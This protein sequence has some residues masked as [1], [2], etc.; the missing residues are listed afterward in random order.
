MPLVAERWRAVCDR[1]PGVDEARLVPE[2]IRDLIGLMVN[3][4]LVE[5]RRRVAEAG[6]ATADEVRGAGRSLSG[7]SAALR[8]EERALKAFL[9]ARMY[10]AVPVQAVRGRAQQVLAGLFAAYRGDPRR[11]PELWRPAT[12]DQ[13]AMMRAI[14]DFIAGMTDRYAIRRYEE[15]VGPADLPEGF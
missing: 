15:L 2:L 14:G 6:V 12:N 4:V 8:D 9:H 1:F 10:D 3:D 11:L 5:T 7:F 13:P